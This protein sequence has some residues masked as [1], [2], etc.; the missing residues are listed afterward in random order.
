MNPNEKNLDYFIAKL[1]EIADDAERHGLSLVFLVENADPSAERADFGQLTE[2]PKS[3]PWGSWNMG[4]SFTLPSFGERV[5]SW[6]H[7]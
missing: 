5:A 3:L 6:Y 2:A 7:R 1:N 4:K